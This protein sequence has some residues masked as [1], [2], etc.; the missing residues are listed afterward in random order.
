MISQ[1][2]TVW[3]WLAVPIKDCPLS[4]LIVIWCDQPAH[5]CVNM[6]GCSYQGLSTKLADCNLTWSASTV[7]CEHGCPYHLMWQTKF[8]CENSHGRFYFIFQI[9]LLKQPE[10]LSSVWYIPFLVPTIRGTYINKYNMGD[11]FVWLLYDCALSW[12]DFDQLTKL[13]ATLSK[14]LAFCNIQPNS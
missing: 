9:P 1:H 14:C 10:Q 8:K 11:I 5:Y 7:R 12:N 6:A 3:T 2:S 13:G 4:W